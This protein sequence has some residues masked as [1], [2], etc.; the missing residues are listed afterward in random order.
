MVCNVFI[1][2]FRAQFKGWKSEQV[3]VGD[4][5]SQASRM[6]SKSLVSL[7]LVKILPVQ[8]PVEVTLPHATTSAPFYSTAWHGADVA[9]GY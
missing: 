6:E 3:A 7:E 2:R 8:G 9:I 5:V 1:V 4:N